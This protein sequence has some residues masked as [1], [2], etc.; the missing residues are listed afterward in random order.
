MRTTI[1]S[2]SARTG[3][4]SGSS[5]DIARIHASLDSSLIIAPLLGQ[6]APELRRISSFLI[7][8][9]VDDRD[10]RGY[11]KSMTTAATL[12]AGECGNTNHLSA[13]PCAPRT[14][15]IVKVC[16]CGLVH[17]EIDW[18]AN[19]SRRDWDLGEDGLFEMAECVCFSTLVIEVTRDTDGTVWRWQS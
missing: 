3:D 1:A 7:A 9:A 16:G 8:E 18:L 2:T 4:H 10:R 6:N 5:D 12:P 17:S 13:F 11:Q 15:A 14:P 19:A